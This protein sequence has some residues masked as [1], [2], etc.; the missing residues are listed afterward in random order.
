MYMSRVCVYTYIHI[1]IYIY[2]YKCVCIYVCVCMCVQIDEEMRKMEIVK[3][4]S[5]SSDWL[6]KI[7]PVRDML[8]DVTPSHRRSMLTLTW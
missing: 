2:I 8:D 4:H 3:S 7:P 1:Y 5:E 6:E